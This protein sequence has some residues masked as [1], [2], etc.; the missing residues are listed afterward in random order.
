M[1]SGLPCSTGLP[2]RK[3]RL[4]AS[5]FRVHDSSL[6]KRVASSQSD[7]GVWGGLSAEFSVQDIR[8]LTEPGQ[9]ITRLLN[10]QLKGPV[11]LH[12]RGHVKMRLV[13]LSRW[14]SEVTWRLLTHTM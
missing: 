9:G 12:A 6:G 4:L 13:D 7:L 2:N 10:F 11:E 1:T 3:R 8:A 14:Q 5:N